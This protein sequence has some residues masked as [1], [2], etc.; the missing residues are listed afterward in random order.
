M[1]I[2]NKGDYVWVEVTS[3]Y[4]KDSGI[5]YTA[6]TV[7]PKILIPCKLLE[8]VTRKEVL[9]DESDVPDY[10]IESTYLWGSRTSI[11]PQDI[12]RRMSSEEIFAYLMES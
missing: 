3:C 11:Y 9:A 10:I 12:K 7:I 2:F 4:I 5:P 8:D 6:H 1:E